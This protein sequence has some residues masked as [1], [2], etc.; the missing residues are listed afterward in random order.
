GG[1]AG[2]RAVT[3]GSQTVSAVTDINLGGASRALTL[4]PIDAV[5]RADD[6][7]GAL[8][9][10]ER[11]ARGAAVTM[12]IPSSSTFTAPSANSSGWF[13]GRAFDVSVGAGMQIATA[14][15][16]ATGADGS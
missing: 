8:S 14:R 13:P 3:G 9:V 7:P 1:G 4:D 6:P 10:A 2:L 12:T 5:S 16:V 11:A 15:S